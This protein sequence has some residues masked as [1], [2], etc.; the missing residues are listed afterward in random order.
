MAP[1]SAE[2]NTAEPTPCSVVHSRSVPDTDW[3]IIPFLA[4]LPI[5]CFQE[6]LPSSPEEAAASA[7]LSCRRLRV[8]A[9][10]LHLLTSRTRQP[11]RK[12]PTA[13]RLRHFKPTWRTSTRRKIL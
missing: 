5:L 10:R 6:K 2:T 4:K 9:Q 12:S 13:K 3:T 1:V 11:P 7:G 8:K